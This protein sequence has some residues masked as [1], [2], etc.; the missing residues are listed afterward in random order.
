M[1]CDLLGNPF[2]T[3]EGMLNVCGR[4]GGVNTL[5]QGSLVGVPVETIKEALKDPAFQKMYLS[6]QLEIRMARHLRG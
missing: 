6:V 5:E 4:C 3:I 2:Q 1:Q